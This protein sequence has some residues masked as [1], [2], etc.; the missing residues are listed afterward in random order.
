MRLTITL[1]YCLVYLG[2]YAQCPTNLILQTQQEV[3]AFPATYPGCTFIPG[4]IRIESSSITNLDSLYSIQFVQV[5]LNLIDNVGLMDFD[6]LHNLEAIGGDFNLINNQSIVD[7]S[8]LLKLES[9][10]KSFNVF[11]NVGLVSMDGLVQFN[12]I[13]MDLILR[14]NLNLSDL[15]G[16]QNLGVV[17]RNFDVRD[18]HSLVSFNGLQNLIAIGES[19]KVYDNLSLSSLDGLENV[20]GVGYLVA[21]RDN[22]VLG[23]CAVSAVCDAANSGSNVIIRDN[24]IG[25]SSIPEVVTVCALVLPVQFA[26]HSAEPVNN[27]GRDVRVL[28]ATYSE[29]NNDYYTVEQLL[30]RQW[31]EVGIIHGA[32][33]TESKSEYEWVHTGAGAQDRFYRIKQTDY[34]GAFTYSKLFTY[35][36]PRQLDQRNALAPNPAM[37]EVQLFGTPGTTVMVRNINGLQCRRFEMTSTVHLMDVSTLKAGIYTVHLTEGRHEV[38]HR[39]VKL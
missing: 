17:G 12:S 36:A 1:L 6:G 29:L 9:V 20:Q 10:G 4:S 22:D 18:A 30:N 8:G 27:F 21:I 33:T 28:W 37:D 5:N 13:G 32:G 34:D 7:F 23:D 19:L 35:Q 3:D 2:I 24:A 39:L 16:L 25:C 15:T 11:D 31:V 38:T 26:S 14:G